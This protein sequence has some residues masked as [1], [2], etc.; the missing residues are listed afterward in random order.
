MRNEEIE[1]APL[2]ARAA[3]KWSA[4]PL[5]LAGPQTPMTAFEVTGFDRL[6]TI[7]RS[8]DDPT[9][10][11]AMAVARGLFESSASS[12]KRRNHNGNSRNN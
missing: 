1:I 4:G 11:Y 6:L 12:L 8:N 9:T 3:S 5:V 10:P 2:K 7:R